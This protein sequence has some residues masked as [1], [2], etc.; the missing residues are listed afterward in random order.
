MLSLFALQ[1]QHGDE[2]PAVNPIKPIPK[3]ATI[4]PVNTFEAKTDF[5]MAKSFHR[6]VPYPRRHVYSVFF[7]FS[8]MP[9]EL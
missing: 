6:G 4:A 2:H 3:P 1:P 5:L 8:L 7:Y 9:P